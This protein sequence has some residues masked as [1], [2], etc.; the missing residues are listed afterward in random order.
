M[1]NGELFDWGFSRSQRAE[2]S[3]QITELEI[4]VNL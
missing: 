1:S 2:D 3:C 4:R